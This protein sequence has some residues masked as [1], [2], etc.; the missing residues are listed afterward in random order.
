MTNVDPDPYWDYESGFT[1]LLKTD[2]IWLR[3]HNTGYYNLATEVFKIKKTAI[4]NVK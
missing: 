1:K 2:P 3:I 4:T